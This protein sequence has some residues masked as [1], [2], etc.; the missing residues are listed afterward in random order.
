MAKQEPTTYFRKQQKPAAIIIMENDY[1]TILHNAFETENIGSCIRV[2]FAAIPV[3]FKKRRK[4]TWCWLAQ[5]AQR[6]NLSFPTMLQRVF[7][8]GGKRIL[9]QNQTTTQTCNNLHR[10]IHQCFM[11]L[12]IPE[13][14]CCF[15][16]YLIYFVNSEI[17]IHFQ[18]V[19]LNSCCPRLIFIEVYSFWN[20]YILLL[21]TLSY[22]CQHPILSNPTIANIDFANPIYC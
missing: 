14:D 3:V 11:H 17:N 12:M 4:A 7:K 16:K 13:T 10:T 1:P 19:S 18:A 2:V 5:V 22:Y 8:Q 20:L 15:I 6:E 9:A 21:L